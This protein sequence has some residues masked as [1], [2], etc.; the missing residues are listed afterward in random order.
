[1]GTL[2]VVSTPIGNLEDITLR[3]LRVMQEVSLVAA[4]DTRTARKL[5]SH[6]GI[7]AR[8]VSYNE[9]NMK[10]RTPEL[11]QTLES[12][13][14]ALVSDAGTPGLSDPGA[15]LIDAASVAG[16]PVSPIPGPVAAVAALAVSGLP[17][18]Q[19]TFIGFPPRRQGERRSAFSR[20]TSDPA[21]LILYESPHRLQKSLADLLAV[22]G[23][24]RIAVARELTKLYEE[25]FRGTISQALDH[26]A[27]PRGEFTIVVEGARETVTDITDDDLRDAIHELRRQG[28]SNRDA[29]TRVAHDTGTPRKRVY[30]LSLED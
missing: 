14:V 5:L 9:H 19:F 22:L 20:F 23:D 2:Y 25:V 8:I 1:M 15:E 18:R 10:H 7:K 3:A 26:F 30:S 6:H 27:E 24:R 11:L 21:T 12:G 28:V 16:F 29:V 13:D 4:E 17:M